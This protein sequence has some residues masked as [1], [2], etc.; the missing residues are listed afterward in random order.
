MPPDSN[1]A[2]LQAIADLKKHVDKKHLEVQTMLIGDMQN[3]GGLSGQVDDFHR[4]M[5]TVV[6]RVGKVEVAAKEESGAKI[7]AVSAHKRIDANDKRL[8]GWLAGGI[9]TI[10]GSIGGLVIWVATVLKGI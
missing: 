8:I 4:R 7:A 2:V 9:L 3:P 6:D 10:L 5:D 1:H